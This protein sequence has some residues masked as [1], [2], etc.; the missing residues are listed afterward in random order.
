MAAGSSLAVEAARRA[1]SALEPREVPVPLRRVRE[2]NRPSLPLP[3]ERRLLQEIEDNEWF[4]EQ[5]AE[6]FE[7]SAE[8]F[9][10]EEL[11]AALFLFRPEGWEDGLRDAAR[12]VEDA[13][14]AVRIEEMACQIAKLESELED[15]QS[16][17]K[18]F[19]RMMEEAKKEAGRRAAKAGRFR[20][21]SSL[22][23][24]MIMPAGAMLFCSLGRSSPPASGRTCAGISLT[25]C[26][27]RSLSAVCPNSRFTASASPPRFGVKAG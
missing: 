1:L 23:C 26:C 17:A 2:Q 18:R 4:R 24:A 9:D 12:T 15:W 21:I 3:F 6:Q 20:R 25:N 27:R 13:R 7:G 5:T 16:K 19:R 11:A 22:C 14:Q 10:P 8:A